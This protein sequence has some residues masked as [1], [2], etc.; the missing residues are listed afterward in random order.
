MKDERD[1][2]SSHP[3]SGFVVKND[4][5][6]R[7]DFMM[8]SYESCSARHSLRLYTSPQ[9][10]DHEPGSLEGELPGDRHARMIFCGVSKGV[11]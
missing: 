4:V 7:T 11:C 2:I 8:D 1:G 5:F 3:P 9:N 6:F 10:E